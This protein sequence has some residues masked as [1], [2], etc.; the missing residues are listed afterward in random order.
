[1]PRVIVSGVVGEG[2]D[3]GGAG[4]QDS[5]HG[6]AAGDLLEACE[7][8]GGEVALDGDAGVDQGQLRAGFGGGDLCGG[9]LRL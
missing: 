9:E 6:A 1:M 7:L 5:V 2:G 3:D 4:T 8:L